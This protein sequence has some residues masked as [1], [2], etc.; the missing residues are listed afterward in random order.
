MSSPVSLLFV[1]WL[2]L[3]INSIGSPIIAICVIDKI[4]SGGLSLAGIL[5]DYF[6]A[7][8]RIFGPELVICQSFL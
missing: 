6:S 4:A 5:L 1:I 7:A 8:P 2:K 3:L